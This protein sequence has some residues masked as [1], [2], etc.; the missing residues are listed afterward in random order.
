[1]KVRAIA[2]A[3]ERSNVIGT[4]ELE[5]TPTGL[6][7]VYLSVA[8][9]SDG[10]APGALASDAQ[11]IVPWASVREARVEGEQLYLALDPAVT[12]H[13][14]LT[15]T[16]FSAGDTV[17]HREV[18]RQRVILR[19]GATGAALVSLLVVA[20]MVPRIA[21]RTSALTALLIGAA[22]A[23]AV[24]AVGLIADRRVATGGADSDTIRE[25]LIAQLS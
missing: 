8:A 23:L 7:L 10:Y 6:A 9:F 18:Y 17:H 12:P 1:M 19:I 13:N 5:C 15:L 2:T 22:T 21:P 3:A 4:V 25:A 20:L 16:N 14:R 24:L 11:L